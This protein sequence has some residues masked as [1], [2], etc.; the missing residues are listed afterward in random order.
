MLPSS[1]NGVDLFGSGPHRFQV[2][3]RGYLVLPDDN[4]FIPT[5]VNVAYGVFELQVFVRGR[6][7]APTESALW[8]V[9]DA[10]QDVL[11]DYADAALKA[12]LVDLHGR[13][14]TDMVFVRIEF[15]EEVDRGRAVSVPYEARF[16]RLQ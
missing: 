6:L 7:V 8:A 4:S 14:W 13:T 2:G 5:T 16:H 1:F 12:D 11:D 10:V 9:R 15:G 3:R